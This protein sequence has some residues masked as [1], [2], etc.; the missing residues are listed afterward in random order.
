MC[1]L[2]NI[3]GAEQPK[4]AISKMNLTSM[5]VSMFLLPQNSENKPRRE[6]CVS[7]SIGLAYSW[8]ETYVTN[9]QK[10]Y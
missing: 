7:K 2:E 4:R 3:C 6:I 8:K 5:E 9:L 1:Y 10:V